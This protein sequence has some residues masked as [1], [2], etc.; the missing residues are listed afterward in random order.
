MSKPKNIQ[1]VE[2]LLLFSVLML[3]VTYK[4]DCQ[5][6]E[7]S[8]Q[9]PNGVHYKVASNAA[10]ESAKTTLV[11]GLASGADLPDGLFDSAVTCG[12]TLWKV[13]QPSADKTLL[14]SKVVVVLVNSVQTE[15]RG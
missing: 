9:V 8:V 1:R 2:A 4:A 11:R 5:A 7:N 13:L 3:V 12:P 15:G 10:N 6:V 14:A